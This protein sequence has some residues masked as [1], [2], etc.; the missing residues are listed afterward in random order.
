MLKT[1]EYL[2]VYPE[3]SHHR[4]EPL[5][6]A[7]SYTSIHNL[8]YYCNIVWASAYKSNLSRLVILQK[9]AVRFIAKLP[10]GAH[11]L[12][13][14]LRLKILKPDQI[15][16]VQI[17]IFMYRYTHNQLPS[18]YRNYFQSNTDNHDRSR[19]FKP[20]YIPFARTNNRLVSKKCAGPRAW[21]SI[22]PDIRSIPSLQLFKR[23]L[24]THIQRET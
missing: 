21:N 16:Q 5:S 11:T 20:Y 7:L 2:H 8:L 24:S 19:N 4:L 6:T 3:S 22:P 12:T 10:Y 23:E 15:R 17:G 13:E 14:F 18:T 9:R 1:W